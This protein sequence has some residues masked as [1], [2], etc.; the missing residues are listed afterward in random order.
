MAR[1]AVPFVPMLH[2]KQLKELEQSP[3]MSRRASA[4][5]IFP[6]PSVGQ[7][8]RHS[9]DTRREK[10][11][12]EHLNETSP[13][14]LVPRVE[15][16]GSVES[17][18]RRS[19]ENVLTSSRRCFAGSASGSATGVTGSGLHSSGMLDGSESQLLTARVCEG[20]FIS[21]PSSRPGSRRPSGS[22]VSNWT[23]D[24]MPIP[25]RETD[26]S[27]LNGRSRVRFTCT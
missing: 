8:R 17:L 16:Q 2:P 9:C 14:N 6:L 12:R 13:G 27:G 18:S 1:E 15:I 25:N 23:I 11:S 10:G 22:S 7:L 24:P 26:N 20:P 19:S 3:G 21:A 5:V 4:H